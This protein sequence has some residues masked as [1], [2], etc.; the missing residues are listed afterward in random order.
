ML[1]SIAVGVVAGFG[2]A[3]KAVKI[4]ALDVSLAAFLA[5]YPVVLFYFQSFSW[6]GI[7]ANLI[8]VPV[9]ALILPLGFISLLP[10]IGFLGAVPAQ[11]LLSSVLW[12]L[13]RMADQSW[14]CF[15]LP[16]PGLF[17]IFLYYILGGAVLWFGR[18]QNESRLQSAF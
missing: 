17:F 9:F 12:I 14:T 7:F 16:Q 5:T 6:M 4:P 3:N 11:F 10:G 2:P 8:A 1:F 13:K 18:R 15:A